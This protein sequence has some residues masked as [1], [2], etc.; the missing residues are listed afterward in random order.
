MTTGLRTGEQS[1]YPGDRSACNESGAAQPAASGMG[2]CYR[3]ERTG[4][5]RG[6]KRAASPGQEL[7][8]QREG[9][10]RCGAGRV[11]HG[12]LGQAGPGG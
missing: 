5:S 7:G 4:H 9:L 12:D 11:G 3:K 6:M 10:P 2:G 1:T 8:K